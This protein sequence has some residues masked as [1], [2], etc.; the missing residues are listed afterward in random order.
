MGQELLLLLLLLILVKKFAIS[1][2]SSSHLFRP[3][4]LLGAGVDIPQI[5]PFLW[6]CVCVCLR[7]CVRMD[8]WICGRSDSRT[9][10][11]IAAPA[12]PQIGFFLHQ[13]IHSGIIFRRN[14]QALFIVPARIHNQ[15]SK[16]REKERGPSNWLPLIGF[17][18][19]HAKKKRFYFS[20]E[21]NWLVITH[22]KKCILAINLKIAWLFKKYCCSFFSE[23]SLEGP[24]V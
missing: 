24:N 23:F 13:Q 11:A 19:I 17:S 6:V 21:I 7:V 8:Q 9:K 3:T 10:E 15:F 4:F 2:S 12:R 5:S 20:L 22:V 18:R 16:W 1:S 14:D